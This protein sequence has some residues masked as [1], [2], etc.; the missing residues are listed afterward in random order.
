VPRPILDLVMQAIAEL[1]PT[2][3]DPVKVES[4][5]AAALYGRTGVL[6]SLALVTLVVALEQLI[7]EEYDVSVALADERAVSQSSSPFRTI[8]SLASYAASRI[9]EARR[10]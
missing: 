8:G 1:N 4:G 2:L 7:E 3:P 5:E 10:A 9:E 6:D